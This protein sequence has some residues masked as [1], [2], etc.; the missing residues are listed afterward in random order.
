MRVPAGLLPNLLAATTATLVLGGAEAWW[1]ATGPFVAAAQIGLLALVAFPAGVALIAVTRALWR[2]WRTVE[3]VDETGAAPLLLAWLIYGALGTA[4]LMVGVFRMVRVSSLKKLPPNAAA[5]VA[6]LTVLALVAVVVALSRPA[7]RG[8]T[9]GLRRLDRAAHARWGRRPLRP[10]WILL[11]V[12]LAAAVI[13][14]IEWHIAILPRLGAWNPWVFIY[15]ALFLVVL[16]GA[17]TGYAALARRGGARGRRLLRGLTIG[18]SAV[19]LVSGGAAGWARARRIP[20]LL[21]IWVRA[22]LAGEVVELLFDPVRVGAGLPRA[23]ATPTERAGAEHPD[24]LLVT[25]DAARGDYVPPFLGAAEMPAVAGL[26]RTGT[27]FEWA[28]APGATTRRSVPAIMTGLLPSRVR[29]RSVKWSF[30]LDPRHVLLAER[31]RAAG[32]ETAAFLCC[33]E[34]F[35]PDLGLDRGFETVVFHRDAKALSAAAERWMAA[36]PAAEGRRPSFVWIHYYEAHEAHKTPSK[37]GAK[38]DLPSR[39]RRT[40]AVVDGA[41]KVVLAAVDRSGRREHTLIAVTA[42]HGQGLGDHRILYHGYTLYNSEIRVPLVLSGPGVGVARVPAPVSLI[43]LAPTLLDL[44][45]YEPPDGWVMDGR[46]LRA[47]LDSPGTPLDRGRAFSVLMKDAHSKSEADATIQGRYKLIHVA[48]RVEL[49]DFVA[50]PSEKK[51]LAGSL[52]DVRRRL[53]AERAE[54]ERRGRISPF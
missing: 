52:V 22:P 17:H 8:L 28:F 48:D 33:N 4:A 36:R 39:Y 14:P 25:I 12:A 44:A 21:D 20:V 9:A 47:L 54:R 24:I 45:G 40:L 41:L 7:V 10:R 37:E 34:Q 30:K 29:G 5:L 23:S 31:F 13:G 18:L 51:N 11:V 46:S 50:D 6:S 43:D 2:S 16:A 1:Y 38:N 53:E 32:Y 42:D 35:G 3:V 15:P 19:I 27:T 26:A 49:Y